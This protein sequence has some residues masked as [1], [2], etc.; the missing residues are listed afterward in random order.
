MHMENGWKGF[1]SGGEW[2]DKRGCHILG[3]VMVRQVKV[4][5]GGLEEHF[6]VNVASLSNNGYRGQGRRESPGWFW[7]VF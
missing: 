2:R 1:D 4:A 5:A 6:I 3:E 7:V